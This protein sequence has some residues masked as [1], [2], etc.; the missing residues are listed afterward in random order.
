MGLI[1]PQ[2]KAF[3]LKCSSYDTQKLYG[4]ES[5]ERNPIQVAFLCV[6]VFLPLKTAFVTSREQPLDMTGI[7][8]FIR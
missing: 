3:V 8:R 7:I 4:E 6:V 2:I 5:K 1:L